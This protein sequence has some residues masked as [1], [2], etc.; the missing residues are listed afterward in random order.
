MKSNLKNKKIVYCYNVSGVGGHDLLP[1]LLLINDLIEG[2]LLNHSIS[3]PASFSGRLLRDCKF[4]YTTE[5]TACPSST[6]PNHIHIRYN[7]Q[8]KNDRPF[9]ISGFYKTVCYRIA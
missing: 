3:R 1:S 6:F 8:L 5:T 7:I 9:G 4:S 2:D